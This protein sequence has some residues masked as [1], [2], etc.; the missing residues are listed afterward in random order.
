VILGFGFLSL[1]K[2]AFFG[3]GNDELH[4]RLLLICGC[5]CPIMA[6]FLVDNF[7]CSLTVEY[8]THFTIILCMELFYILHFF[9]ELR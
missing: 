7:L 6:L 2:V 5:F 9:R 4:M 8:K 3:M 1:A